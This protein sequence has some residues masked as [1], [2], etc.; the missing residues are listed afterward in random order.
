[1]SRLTPETLLIRRLTAALQNLIE[2]SPDPGSEALGAVWE[3]K[4]YQEPILARDSRCTVCGGSGDGLTG[5]HYQPDDDFIEAPYMEPCSACLGT[6]LRE[7][8]RVVAQRDAFSKVIDKQARQIVD[9]SRQRDEC[10]QGL[11]DDG[12]LSE[13]EEVE[14]SEILTDSE[15]SAL[16][17]VNAQLKATRAEYAEAGRDYN[18]VLAAQLRERDQLLA[19]NAKLYEALEELSEAP[20]RSPEHVERA[21]AV[22]RDVKAELASWSSHG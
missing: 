19:A 15:P 5:G 11:S 13:A 8:Q 17:I 21:E 2:G 10:A 14:L 12:M 9:V 3:G 18:K 1:M 6:G 4:H 20:V 7:V 22:L 16:E